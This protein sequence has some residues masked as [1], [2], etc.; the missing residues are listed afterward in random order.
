MWTVVIEGR[1]HIQTFPMQNWFPDG[2]SEKIRQIEQV[3]MIGPS[4]HPKQSQR[5]LIG[6]ADIAM[7]LWITDLF[8]MNFCRAPMRFS[9]HYPDTQKNQDLINRSIKRGMA[10]SC[11]PILQTE[12]K[13]DFFIFCIPFLY[14]NKASL[15]EKQKRV[16]WNGR[17]FHHTLFN[18]YQ[19][20]PPIRQLGK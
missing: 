11:M 16:W 20:F 15:P 10:A 13:H 14:Q 7:G 12:W 18:L 6:D 1:P 9:L 4:Q 2:I 8:R 19:K 3:Q 17:S 5:N